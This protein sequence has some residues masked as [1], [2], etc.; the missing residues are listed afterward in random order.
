MQGLYLYGMVLERDTCLGLL[1]AVTDGLPSL[2]SLEFEY[3]EELPEASDKFREV[4]VNR[5]LP[6][7]VA[8]HAPSSVHTIRSPRSTTEPADFFTASRELGVESTTFGV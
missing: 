1:S 3:E 8:I 2:T 5:E 6:M 4:I 7:K